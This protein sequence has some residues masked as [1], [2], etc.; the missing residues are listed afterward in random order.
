MDMELGS[1]LSFLEDEFRDFP[2][3]RIRLSP[4][5]G[6]I[7]S[8]DLIQDYDPETNHIHIERGIFVRTS[9][10]EYYFPLDW[11]KNRQQEKIYRQ[12]EE[13]REKSN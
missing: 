7:R 12:I 6:V 2:E 1:Y 11:W 13:I 8:P 3:V 5:G 4:K 9:L 10:K